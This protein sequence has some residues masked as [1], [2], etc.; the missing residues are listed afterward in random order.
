M[1]KI[2]YNIPIRSRIH[3]VFYRKIEII[4]DYEFVILSLIDRAGG[5]I[6]FNELGVLLGF[7]TKNIDER[8]IRVDNAEAYLLDQ[9]LNSLIKYKLIEKDNGLVNNLFWGKIALEKKEKYKFF[10]AETSLPE[11]FDLRINEKEL[12]NFKN[13]GFDLKFKYEREITD[14]E[15]IELGVDF[16]EEYE[17]DLKNEFWNSSKLDKKIFSIDY[18]EDKPIRFERNDITTEAYINEVNNELSIFYE[19]IKQENLI[20]VLYYEQNKDLLSD[21][22]LK[23]IYA[24]FLD[25]TETINSNNITPFLNI[26]N[27]EQIII[28]KRVVWEDKFVDL[29][30]PNSN[31]LLCNLTSENCELAFLGSNLEKYTNFWDWDVV[32]ERVNIHFILDNLSIYPWNF[33]YIIEEL[34]VNELEKNL[35]KIIKIIDNSQDDIAILIPRISNEFLL[36]NIKSISLDLNL[37]L[38]DDRDNF[39]QIVFS[40]LEYKWDWYY[41]ISNI[42]LQ[43]FID[44][45]KKVKR[46]IQPEINHFL[47]TILD[48]KNQE[49]LN[50]TYDFIKAIVKDVNSD[51][52]S[53]YNSRSSIVSDINILKLLNSSNLIYWGDNSFPGFEKNKNIDWDI[54]QLKEFINFFNYQESIDFLSSTISSSL[55]I[56]EFNDLNWN[57]EMISENSSLISIDGF[58]EKEKLRLNF[59]KVAEHID[60]DFLFDKYELIKTNITKENKEVFSN[61]I[62]KRFSLIQILEKEKLINGDLIINNWNGVFNKASKEILLF[63]V[64]QYFDIIPLLHNSIQFSKLITKEFSIVEILANKDFDWDWHYATQLLLKEGLNDKDLKNYADKL[65]WPLIIEEYY[66][67]DDLLLSN[68]LPIISALVNL[69]NDSIVNLTWEVITNKYPY[70]DFN[71]AIQITFNDKQYKWNWDIISSTEKI[72]TKLESLEKYKDKINWELL[73]SNHILNEIFNRLNKDLFS[74]FDTW[75]T[76]V[77]EYLER[78]TDRWDFNKLSKVTSITWQQ[79]IVEKFVERWDWEVL[80]SESSRLLS[81]KDKDSNEKNAFRYS[82]YKLDKFEDFINWQIISKRRDLK[83]S[84]QFV[85]KHI[86]KDWDWDELSR[87]PMFTPGLDFLIEYSDKEWNWN[88]FSKVEWL[89]SDYIKG[90]PDEDWDWENISKNRNFSFD[91]DFLKILNLKENV[92]WN[93]IINSPNLKFD[94]ESLKILTNK[95]INNF[96][97]IISKS[98]RL[99]IDDDLLS[100]YRLNW[101]WNLLIEYNKI[102]I[103]N[104]E[105]LERYESSLPWDAISSSTSFKASIEV[106]TIF[107]DKLNWNNVSSNLELNIGILRQFK[108]YLDWEVISSNSEIEFDQNLVT[109]FIDVLDIYKLKSNPSIAKEAEDFIDSYLAD[110]DN[111]RFV[112]NLK[113]RRSQW[114][115]SIYHFTHITNAVNVIN[116]KKILSRNKALQ[117]SF[118]DAAGNVVSIKDTAHSYARFY[119][120]PQTPTQFYNECLGKDNSSGRMG[121]TKKHGDWVEEWKSDFPKAQNLGLPKCPIPV[122]FKF[123]INEVLNTFPALCEI[124][125]GNMQKSNTRK[126]HISQ[127]L[128][129]FSFDDVYSTIDNTSD[130][131]WKTYLDKSQQEFLIKNELDFSKL[132]NIEI[133]VRTEEDKQQLINLVDSNIES[134]VT[135]DQNQECYHNNNKVIDYEINNNEFHIQSDYQGNGSQSGEFWLDSESDYE[136]VSGKE[137]VLYMKDK[138]LVFYPEIELSFSGNTCFTA[139]F[140]DKVTNKP[141]W[142]VVKYCDNDSL[143]ESFKQT[144]DKDVNLQGSITDSS[145]I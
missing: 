46:Y 82:E 55:V 26:V 142:E 127:M 56:D 128:H 27:W 140:K 139:Y 144:N 4:E 93:E 74:D 80:S 53:K 60:V 15:F 77:I 95:N 113:N 22:T 87:N 62:S 43:F 143:E 73:S 121:L 103:N 122:F 16:Q 89:T 49:S 91:I 85:A 106:I 132:K 13:L 84:E 20:D 126:G 31:Q 33:S 119:F 92:D 129:R 104:I 18:I 67:K 59:L 8:N 79:S 94:I 81:E 45:Y 137:N 78:Y 36:K 17:N 63:V 25:S 35:N 41:V 141:E 11:F 9:F 61:I 30:L 47:N 136:I 108:D 34:E 118:S 54:F 6:E 75:K 101:N 37:F 52:F 110:N 123:D 64:K 90:L 51:S 116:S 96:W 112:F 32:T 114:S 130:R 57:W 120:R 1:N 88:N 102:D 58:I 2:D 23:C 98:S 145:S 105:L 134:I 3:K 86:K 65:Y 48:L 7:A 5:S 68:K 125:D 40:Y 69:S 117:S 111:A 100:R 24:N 38:Y 131:D 133:I 12:F 21:I 76:K 42:N 39:N 70:Y 99:V 107:K 109:E 83:I 29:F 115:G 97:N 10:S 44:N 138:K 135:V 66:T 28:D 72:D 14:N 124:S 50:Y 19:D 71:D